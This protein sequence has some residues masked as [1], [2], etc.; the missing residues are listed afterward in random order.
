ML[1]TGCESQEM[2]EQ[3]SIREREELK[4]INTDDTTK[5]YINEDLATRRAKIFSMARSPQKRKLFNQTWTYN[6]SIKVMMLNGDIKTACNLNDL[7]ALVPNES[8]SVNG[9][10]IV[11]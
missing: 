8:F 10:L 6:G 3:M 11:P 9:D 2:A 4:H 5:V 1:A 7:P